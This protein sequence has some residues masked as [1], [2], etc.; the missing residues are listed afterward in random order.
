M[1]IQ[2][3]LCLAVISAPCALSIQDPN[4]RLPCHGSSTSEE[5]VYDEELGAARIIRRRLHNVGGHRS[6]PLVER[7]HDRTSRS[8]DSDAKLSPIFVQAQEIVQSFLSNNTDLT[9][10]VTSYFIEFLVNS[11]SSLDNAQFI[12]WLQERLRQIPDEVITKTLDYVIALDATGG[13]EDTALGMVKMVGGVSM[14]KEAIVNAVPE[15]LPSATQ[16][17]TRVLE[18]T[19]KWVSDKEFVPKSNPS[20][21]IVTKKTCSCKEKSSPTFMTALFGTGREKTCSKCNNVGYVMTAV[22]NENYV[23]EAE[24]RGYYCMKE[25]A[26]TDIANVE[27]IV[28]AWYGVSLNTYSEKEFIS[29]ALDGDSLGN[30]STPGKDVTEALRSKIHLKNG[31]IALDGKNMNALFGDPARGEPK[32][33]LYLT[34]I[35]ENSP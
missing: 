35:K 34:Y 33:T 1:F 29:G 11:I 30:L 13:L 3:I 9:T 2:Q 28:A 23:D 17:I 12:G 27:R 18:S 31:T 16:Y 19:Y 21:Y 6:R 32:K 24:R 14:I 5:M 15:V 10:N 4:S 7:L 26:A 22:R 8:G 25:H 20:E